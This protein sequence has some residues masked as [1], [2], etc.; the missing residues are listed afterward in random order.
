MLD[1]AT[2]NFPSAY[3]HPKQQQQNQDQTN[4]ET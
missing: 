2:N 1:P 3:H 4:E